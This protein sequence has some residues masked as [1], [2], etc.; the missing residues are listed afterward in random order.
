MLAP[1]QWTLIRMMLPLAVWRGTLCVPHRVGDTWR[2][3][4]DMISTVLTKKCGMAGITG[5]ELRRGATTYEIASCQ[6]NI[7]NFADTLPLGR[8]G[9]QA[10]AV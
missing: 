7:D 1:G 10:T 4:L 6:R 9:R 2:L 8:L 5:S 3:S